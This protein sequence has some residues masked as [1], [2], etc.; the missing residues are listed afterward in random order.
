MLM[1]WLLPGLLPVVLCP[2]LQVNSLSWG[3]EDQEELVGTSLL[4]SV[5]NSRGM[6]PL[7]GG[8]EL[9]V[10]R[11]LSGLDSNLSEVS[12]DQNSL[13]LILHLLCAA[14]APQSLDSIPLGEP[15]AGRAVPLKASLISGEGLLICIWHQGQSLLQS[16]IN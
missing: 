15:C 12:S 16:V 14:W 10:L 9:A 7:E 11:T 8:E 13:F 6:K 4:P 3:C 1:A 2:K 5:S